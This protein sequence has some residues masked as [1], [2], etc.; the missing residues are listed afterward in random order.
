A[1][2]ALSGVVHAWSYQAGSSVSS[3]RP[4]TRGNAKAWR[5]SSDVP[6]PAGDQFGDTT[7]TTS[8]LLS[9]SIA[10]A[11]TARADCAPSHC[12]S[13]T[14]ESPPGTRSNNPSSTTMGT[15]PSSVGARTTEPIRDA[16]PSR[17]R[18]DRIRG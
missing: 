8:A 14:T 1:C 15:G 11:E 4:F 10:W 12:R 7:A 17:Y 6:V 13:A 5:R 2:E 16:Q 9:G 18:E 3:A